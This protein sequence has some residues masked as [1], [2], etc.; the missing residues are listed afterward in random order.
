MFFVNEGSKKF[1]AVLNLKLKAKFVI[2]M[3]LV[4]LRTVQK[5]P[6]TTLMPV[7]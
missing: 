3:I 1:K 7:R 5:E 2:T 4:P 6:Q